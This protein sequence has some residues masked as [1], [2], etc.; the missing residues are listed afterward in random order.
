MVFVAG[1]VEVVFCAA[2]AASVTFFGAALKRAKENS[3]PTKPRY[4]KHCSTY[5][6][7]R[8]ENRTRTQGTVS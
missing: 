6:K 5:G 2:M 3:I 8:N 7:R 4:K 1:A